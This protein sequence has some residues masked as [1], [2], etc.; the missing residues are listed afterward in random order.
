M[1]LKHIGVA[2]VAMAALAFLMPVIPVHTQQ[3][4][5][6]IVVATGMQGPASSTNGDVVAFSGTAGNA[7]Q[8]LANCNMTSTV[9]QCVSAGVI[10][11]STDTGLSRDSAGVWDVG[12]GSQGDK[13]GTV[14]AAAG[15]FTGF[16]TA[17]NTQRLTAD[18]S[19]IAA[20]TPGTAVFTWP[21]L[22]INANYS[23]HCEILY[24]QQTSNAG[25][26]LAVQGATNAPTRLDSWGNI[27]T[28]NAGVAAEG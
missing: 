8:D 3:V 4:Q 7:T 16:L 24:N 18:A 21:A 5:G 20:T 23:F 28:S 11:L 17:A 14:K 19:P 10:R 12:N 22:P 2:V 26:G 6:R 25:I 9:L 27:F 13:S 1:K 15:T